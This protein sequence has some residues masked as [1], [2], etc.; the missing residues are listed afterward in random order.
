MQMFPA[1]EIYSFFPQLKEIPQPIKKLFVEMELP[2]GAYSGRAHTNYRHSNSD[3]SPEAYIERMKL[4]SNTIP[5]AFVGSRRCTSYGIQSCT[6][7]IAGLAGYP[8]S[9]VSGLALGID[10]VAHK[11]AI[12]YNIPTIAFPGS[13]LDWRTL[14]P[15]QH[16]GLA[17]NIISAGGILCSEYSPHTQAAPWTFPQRNRLMAGI[18]VMV[19]VIEAEHDSGSLITARLATEY[20]KIV[21]AVPGPITSPLSQGTNRLIQQGALLVADAS[22]ILQELH[23]IDPI[24][25]SDTTHGSHKKE[26]KETREKIMKDRTRD[27]TN[28]PTNNNSETISKNY[29]LS[30]NEQ[31]VL[32]LLREPMTKDTVIQTLGL[33]AQEAAIIFSLLELR[34][35]IRDTIGIV[36]RI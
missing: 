9:I 11:T 29:T 32:S 18:S 28:N 31:R 17:E 20:N 8:V 30:D 19:V 26:R 6:S 10:A 23:L 34:G 27:A 24:I 36:E 16:Y 12:E 33:S 21:G 7:I 13:G 1:S 2:G 3:T 14:Y 35:L 25:Y 22:D 5:I 15:K 4:L